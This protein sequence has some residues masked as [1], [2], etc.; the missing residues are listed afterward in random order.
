MRKTFYL[1]NYQNSISF[2][3]CRA[4]D[5]ISCMLLLENSD[6]ETIK[7][8]F[9]LPFLIKFYVSLNLLFLCKTKWW[10]KFL[11]LEGEHEYD[12]RVFG[13]TLTP[14]NESI[15]GKDYN[16]SFDLGSYTWSSRG[17]FHF[18]MSLVDAIYGDCKHNSEI[19]QV[20]NRKVF[21]P[22][23]GGYEG[24]YYDL[25]VTK[26]LST[27]TYSRFN[28]EKSRI[29]IEVECETGVPHRV[30]WG[31]PD[32]CYSLSW[33]ED[34]DVMGLVRA[35]SENW[36]DVAIKKFVDDIQNCRVGGVENDN[37]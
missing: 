17:G 35:F 25:K 4:K 32:R 9:Y 2:E 28:M 14:C 36:C 8:Y 10:R 31:T 34:S 37:F 15:L 13:F 16:L 21:I 20:V 33:H 3:I 11:L 6:E 1:T 7:F 23:A 30:K 27:W 5:E 24:C 26:S 18:Y 22:G 12:G 19:L 29:L